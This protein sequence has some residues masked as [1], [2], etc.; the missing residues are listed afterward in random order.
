MSKMVLIVDDDQEQCVI[1]EALISNLDSSIDIRITTSP[2]DA[3]EIA[4]SNSIDCIISDFMMPGM[5]GLE[6]FE[7]LRRN[8]YDKL[9]IILTGHP[10]EIIQPETENAGVSAIYEKNTTFSVYYD[11]VQM[12]NEQETELVD[13]KNKAQNGI[14]LWIFRMFCS[15]IE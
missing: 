10:R 12:M 1:A 4:K 15:K 8:G 13:R 11:I 3:L 6:L 5:N 2:Y 7:M 14:L 9:F